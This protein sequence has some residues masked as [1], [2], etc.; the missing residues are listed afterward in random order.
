MNEW[1]KDYYNSDGLIV[2]DPNFKRLAYIGSYQ[3]LIWTERFLDCGE[4]ELY[5]RAD[6]EIMPYLQIDNFI[7]RDYRE[8]YHEPTFEGVICR[9]AFPEVMVI[10][11][12][13]I[14]T[15]VEQGNYVIVSG[16]TWESILDRRVLFG[17]YTFATYSVTT[18]L[19][20]IQAETNDTKPFPWSLVM[21]NNMWSNDVEGDFYNE[22]VLPITEPSRGYELLKL[23]QDG[24]RSRK[25][26]FRFVY[27]RG[28]A[29]CW[30]LPYIGHDRTGRVLE[31]PAVIFSPE[32]HNLISSDYTFD[33]TTGKNACYT[34]SDGEWYEEKLTTAY[35]GGVASTGLD[36][37]EMF[38]K[39][40]VPIRDD[41]GTARAEATI[42]SELT[43]KGTLEL[44]NHR[45]TVTFD[46]EV[47]ST[48]R[49]IYQRDYFLGDLVRVE[50]GLGMSVFAR[51]VEVNQVW[52]ENGYRI[53]PVLEVD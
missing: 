5:M 30:G 22:P 37:R 50:N 18:L 15:D 43:K 48:D 9:S 19:N 11:K 7:T 31:L 53:V 44:L 34:A 28:D 21:V 36:Y 49:Y 51:V 2:L 3:S 41:A 24:C 40:D 20:L 38:L 39:S 4:F 8:P 25:C 46:F 47:Q 35:Y 17:T 16:R 32:Y 27:L 12:I 14:K 42:N 45:P 6:L 1:T 23:I 52:D 13:Q 10:E 29:P 33:S 26:G